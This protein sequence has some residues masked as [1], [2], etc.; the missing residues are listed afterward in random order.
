MRNMKGAVLLVDDDRENL[1]LYSKILFDDGFNVKTALNS[2]EAFKHLDASTFDILVLDI[3]LGNESGLDILKSIKKTEK[4]SLMSVVMITGMHTSSTQQA[5]GLELGADGYITRPLSAREFLA[6][7]NAF[8]RHKK[9][10]NDL[11]K[12]EERFYKIVNNNPDAIMLG[13]PSGQIRFANTAAEHLFELSVDALLQHLFGYPLVVG[14]NA[15]INILRKNKDNVVGEMRTIDLEWE[16]IDTFLTTIRNVT[17]KKKLWE[18][19]L[20]AKDKAEESEKLKTAFLA[21]MSHEI[22]TPM[23]GIL[24]FANLLK[25]NR[26]DKTENTKYLDIIE[27]SGVRLLNIIND[28]IS[29]SKV[30][31]GQ[32]EVYISKTNLKEVLDYIFTF[33]KPET[34]IK[35]LDLKLKMEVAPNEIIVNTDREKLYAILTN[36]V[37]NAIKYTDSGSIEIGVERQGKRIEFCIKDTGIGIPKDRQK[38]IFDRFV[39]ADIADVRALQGAGLGLAITKAYIEMLGG[40]I[41]MESTPEE[42]S[43]FCFNILDKASANSE[44]PKEEAKTNNPKKIN[45]LNM[46]IAEDDETSEMILSLFIKKYCQNLYVVKN[47]LEAVEKCKS[48]KNIDIIFMD[49]KMPVMNGYEAV[50]EIRSFNKEVIII[51]QTAYGLAGDNEKAMEAGCNYY[52]SKPIIRE[53]LYNILDKYPLNHK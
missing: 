3:V 13:E 8:M 30:E 21:N 37:K 11:K 1:N 7:I 18:E 22:R 51:A 49:M 32:M 40:K 33:F 17:D 35:G 31:A 10:L 42:G 34:D 48:D 12:S 41:W 6:R 9:T 50:K 36:L 29:I 44:I 5:S 24:G 43:S 27:K 46:L 16:G 25:E 15:E 2:A 28:L 23:N 47:G 52:L 45:K 20:K 4:F 39:Q 19:L 38:A 14:E 53:D 26:H